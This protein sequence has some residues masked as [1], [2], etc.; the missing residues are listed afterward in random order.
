M[1]RSAHNT[2][3]EYDETAIWGGASSS[4]STMP[5]RSLTTGGARLGV[6]VRAGREGNCR[7]IA[8]GAGRTLDPDGMQGRLGGWEHRLLVAYPRPP[9]WSPLTACRLLG[10][11]SCGVARCTVR[12]PPQLPDCGIW[13]HCASARDGSVAI[14]EVTHPCSNR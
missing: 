3:A 2:R 11:P 10:A 5:R 12:T 13:A 9:A 6:H 14:Q 4:P 1:G 8:V 7:A